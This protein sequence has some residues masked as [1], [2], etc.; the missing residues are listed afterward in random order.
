MD[1]KDVRTDDPI[2]QEGNKSALSKI[3]DCPYPEGSVN[4]EKWMAGFEV[5]K[6]DIKTT[7]DDLKKH[8]VKSNN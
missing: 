8:F 6:M 5:G 1:K 4:Y 7:Q 2:F 3:E